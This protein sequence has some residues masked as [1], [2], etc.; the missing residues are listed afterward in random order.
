MLRLYPFGCVFPFKP[1]PEVAQILTHTLFGSAG[2]GHFKGIQPNNQDT[3]RFA[4]WFPLKTNQ[5]GGFLFPLCFPFLRLSPFPLF[6]L[7]KPPGKKTTQVISP[8]L[9][10][11]LAPPRKP[12]RTSGNPR[13]TLVEPYLRAAPDHPGAYPG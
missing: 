11:V 1:I 13:G 10:L 8:T 12:H 9:V 2:Q 3:L 6:H 7:L 5:Q 4:T